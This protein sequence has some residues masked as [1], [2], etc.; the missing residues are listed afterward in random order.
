MAMRGKGIY[1]KYYVNPMNK[2]EMGF[3]VSTGCN[4]NG[5]YCGCVGPS[6]TSH[7]AF[8]GEALVIDL[9]EITGA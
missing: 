7:L 6:S 3:C 2:T 9:D 8:P 1:M 4:C 5:G